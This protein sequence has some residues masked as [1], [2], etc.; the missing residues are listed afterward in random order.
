MSQ[1]AP[2]Q[3]FQGHITENAKATMQRIK[4][5][6]EEEYGQLS[7]VTRVVGMIGG[8]LYYV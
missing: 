4:W 1:K 2:F 8:L 6:W 3:V 7:G 5:K